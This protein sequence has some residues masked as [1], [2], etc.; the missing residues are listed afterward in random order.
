M[1]ISA[2]GMASIVEYFWDTVSQHRIVTL[3][4][5]AYTAE[6]YAS[7]QILFILQNVVRD[8]NFKNT[9]A[10]YLAL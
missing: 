4:Y 5:F 1:A 10:D 9:L 6:H 7:R 8:I 3:V 2:R